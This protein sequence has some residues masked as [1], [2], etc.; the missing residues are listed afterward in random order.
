ML[1]KRDYD[2]F[3]RELRELL[4]RFD[5]NVEEAYYYFA[6]GYYVFFINTPYGKLRVSVKGFVPKRKIDCIFTQ[7]E[8][9]EI[10]PDRIKNRQNFN[11][12]SGKNNHWERNYDYL[13]MWFEEYLNDLFETD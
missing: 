13:L 3:I 12:F 5:K 4:T 10:V 8:N 7:I 2:R 11:K 9:P 1:Y 6:D